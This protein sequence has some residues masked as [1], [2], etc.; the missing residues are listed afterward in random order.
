MID[1][2]SF[3]SFVNYMAALALIAIA[4]KHILPPLSRNLNTR[5]FV[6]HDLSPAPRLNLM[7][8]RSRSHLFSQMIYC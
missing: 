4:L 8:E 1:V 6:C 7:A 5:C 3:G 2:Q